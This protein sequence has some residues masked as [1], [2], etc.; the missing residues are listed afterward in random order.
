MK[1]HSRNRKVPRS[2]RVANFS[3]STKLKKRTSGVP[4]KCAANENEVFLKH[5]I[6]SKVI[7]WHPLDATQH[8]PIKGLQNKVRFSS[9]KSGSK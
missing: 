2:S 4:K 6:L 1:C 8:L 3:S 5:L 9:R 7:T